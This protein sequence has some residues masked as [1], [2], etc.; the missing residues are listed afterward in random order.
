MVL[1]S[2]CLFTL[3]S[4]EVDLKTSV[5]KKKYLECNLVLSN[6]KAKI[7]KEPKIKTMK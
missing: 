6:N 1:I 2:F 5:K 4:S 3:G 7:N